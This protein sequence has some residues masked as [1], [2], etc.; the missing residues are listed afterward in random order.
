M[1][2][3]G[4]EE[5]G[6]D[7][8]GAESHAHGLSRELLRGKC[9]SCV[10]AVDTESTAGE[11]AGA[12]RHWNMT[13]ESRANDLPASLDVAVL[14]GGFAGNLLAR[15]LMRA[16]PG[17]R[18]GLFERAAERSFK[19]GESTVE[20]ASHY[21]IERL[22]LSSYLY[23]HQLP[24]NGLRFFFDTPDK[25]AELEAMSEIG[26][27]ALP[28]IP[29]FQ[30]DRSRME[31]DLLEMNRRAGV[32]VFCPAKVQNLAMSAGDGPH[33]FDVK[34]GDEVRPVQAR[35]LIDAT[36]RTSLV[37]RAKKL[38]TDQDHP[39]AAVWGRF[40]NVVDLD[41]YGSPA[42]RERVK[43]TSRVLS[44]NHFCYP[45]YWIWF[46]PLGG[47]I[48]SVGVVIER[49]LFDEA[50]RTADGFRRFL[51]G[52][53]AVR[54]LLE[55]AEMIDVMSYGSYTYGTK[56]FFHGAERWGLVGEAAAFSDPLYSPGSDFIAME[57]DFVSDL[58]LRDVAGESVEAVAARAELY[59]GFM[60]YRFDSTMLLYRKL[61]QTL[62]SYELFGLKW[63]FDIACYYNLWVEPYML[64]RHLDAE[65]LKAQLRL[66]KMVPTVIESFAGLFH[67]VEQHLRE[68]GSYF[69]RNL[70]AFTGGL[71]TIEGQEHLGEPAS[72]EQALARTERA[73]HH[74]R[75]RA[76]ELLGRPDLV[77]SAREL[78][79]RHFMLGRPVLPELE[80][81]PQT[82]GVSS[83]TE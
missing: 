7:S 50:W 58:V 2:R 38:R 77:A 73:F 29:S 83:T 13:V 57:N 54:T 47:G 5:Q 65:Y 49:E 74:V 43:H 59:D 26:S 60:Q 4:S 81:G 63:D 3:D 30:I 12:L 76:L 61:Y 53:A 10:C 37:A 79:M 69:D 22:G 33:R 27:T 40:R 9:T 36:G 64:D 24:K 44:T 52:H 16:R 25:D 70:G 66:G 1:A 51:D 20:L 56:R 34:I 80:Q 17:L 35:W 8:K 42:F 78:S 55:P 32:R 21:L 48:T 31:A 41:D 14:G 28:C 6:R 75:K 15:Q 19:V 11:T 72:G 46:I 82:T 67:R 62:G 18:V 23:Q 71:P 68:G 39:M 45:G